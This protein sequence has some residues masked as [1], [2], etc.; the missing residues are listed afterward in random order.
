MSSL[1]AS[2][3]LGGRAWQAADPWGRWRQGWAFLWDFSL[4]T[5]AARLEG[6]ESATRDQGCWLEPD[7]PVGRGLESRE[8]KG[9][10]LG[11]PYLAW[12][13][14][15]FQDQW[16]GFSQEGSPIPLP[17]AGPVSAADAHCPCPHMAS[18]MEACWKKEG[19]R[20]RCALTFCHRGPFTPPQTG[21]HLHPEVLPT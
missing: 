17:E 12:G 16:A 13:T 4:E 3:R 14:V 6:S 19:C 20:Q 21:T 18:F 8:G 7:R 9:P 2:P 1:T 15:R 10:S 11:G 5:Q